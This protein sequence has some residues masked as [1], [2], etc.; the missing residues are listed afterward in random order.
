MANSYYAIPHATFI[1][2]L[3]AALTDKYGAGVTIHYTS[4]SILIF[5]C[6]AMF[7]TGAIKFNWDNATNKLYL[8]RGTG[9]TSG[10]SVD[11]SVTML[12]PIVNAAWTDNSHVILGDTYLLYLGSA[13]A[14]YIG[15]C[16][17]LIGKLSN[18][19]YVFMF[20]CKG[21]TSSST[22]VSYDITAASAIYP[23]VVGYNLSNAGKLYRQ[24]LYF[25][26]PGNL[27]VVNADTTLAYIADLYSV[28][29]A[30][31]NNLIQ[32]NAIFSATGLAYYGGSTW[33]YTS[34][35]AAF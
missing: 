23:I 16:M 33:V 27:A 2:S 11:G 10:T 7:G 6:A 3:S 26:L 31:T 1:A 34:I 19:D 18:N 8:Y 25:A 9:W 15:E 32:A 21:S 35:Y 30:S 28:S 14:S 20:M 4:S 13:G 29:Y 5:S 17:L 24:P 12:S 22:V